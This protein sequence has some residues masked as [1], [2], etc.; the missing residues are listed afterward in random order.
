MLRVVVTAVLLT[1][2]VLAGCDSADSDIVEADPPELTSMPD[3]RGKTVD[4]AV[5]LLDA[6]GVQGSITFPGYMAAWSEAA[7]AIAGT[8]V[9]AHDET[10]AVGTRVVAID[11]FYGSRHLVVDQTPLPGAPLSDDA[12]AALTAGSHPNDTRRPWLTD[13]HKIAVQGADATPCFDCHEPTECGNCH[14]DLL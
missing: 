11:S 13:G 12:T 5:E 3:L 6:A 2:L 1:A 8:V 9:P 10:V 4:D 7:I 14:T